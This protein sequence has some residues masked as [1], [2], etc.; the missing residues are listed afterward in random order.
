MTNLSLRW[1]KKNSKPRALFKCALFKFGAMT[2]YQLCQESVQNIHHGCLIVS[3]T[4]GGNVMCRYAVYRNAMFRNAAGRNAV[5]S[6][7]L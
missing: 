6:N 4:G 5:Y 7:A 2:F 1:S 3:L